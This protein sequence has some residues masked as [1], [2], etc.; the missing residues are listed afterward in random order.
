MTVI[1]FHTHLF[2]CGSVDTTAIRPLERRSL[3]H[4][5]APQALGQAPIEPDEL[6]RLFRAEGVDRVVVLAEV[7]PLTIGVSSSEFVG[8]FC[9]EH[10]ELVPFCAPNPYLERDLPGRVDALV[11]RYGFRGIKLYPSYLPIAP[12]DARLYPLY[13]YAQERRLPVMFHTGVSSFP[14]SRLRYGDPLLLD[15]VAVDFPELPLI[16]AHGGRDLWYEVAF[17]LARTHPNV[18]LEIS[19]IPPSQL[20]DCFPRLDAIPGKVIFGTDF[21]VLRSVGDNISAIRG[22]GLSEEATSDLLGGTASRLLS[23]VRV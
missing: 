14:G 10:D 19:G 13:S 8:E 12:N 2:P 23:E 5:Y 18:Y 17:T 21:P 15:E 4:E 7:T 9:S 22:L 11:E 3:L 16:M 6:V 20:L 1:D